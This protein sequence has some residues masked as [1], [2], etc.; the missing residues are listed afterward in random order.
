MKKYSNFLFVL[1]RKQVN[2]ILVFDYEWKKVFYQVGQSS[3]ST[4]N[5]MFR[6]SQPIQ[7]FIFHKTTPFYFGNNSLQIQFASLYFTPRVLDFNVSAVAFSA[8]SVLFKQSTYFDPNFLH[9]F[10]QTPPKRSS[11]RRLSFSV[12]LFFL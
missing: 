6:I 2:S 11:G 8:D 5:L 12:V 1:K 3:A 9:Y 7:A 10:Q 4:F